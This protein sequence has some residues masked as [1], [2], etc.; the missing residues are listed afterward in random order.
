MRLPPQAAASIA[1][2]HD[3]QLAKA[4]SAAQPITSSD[5]DRAVHR[6]GGDQRG[7]DRGDREE[8]REQ[9]ARL[10]LAV[11]EMRLAQPLVAQVEA[12]RFAPSVGGGSA[13]GASA[14]TGTGAWNIELERLS[15]GELPPY[16]QRL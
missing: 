7:G 3:T 9:G 16:P 6:P 8:G 15:G 13:S 14:S 1:R 2:R 5:S 10:D 4:T 11:V 12:D